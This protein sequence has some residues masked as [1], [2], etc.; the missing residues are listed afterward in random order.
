MIV[1]MQNSELVV[2]RYCH[3]AALY[4]CRM[5]CSVDDT[6]QNFINS[7]TTIVICLPYIRVPFHVTALALVY[8]SADDGDDDDGKR[9]VEVLPK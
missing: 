4:P 5:R 1:I 3:P 7:A 8:R 2:Y 9:K 6:Q